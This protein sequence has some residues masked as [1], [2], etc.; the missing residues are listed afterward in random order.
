MQVYNLYPISTQHTL[1]PC[2]G[3][4]RPLLM[5]PILCRPEKNLTILARRSAS[6]LIAPCIDKIAAICACLVWVISWNKS[7]DKYL[8]IPMHET[9]SS[10][11]RSPLASNLRNLWV[12]TRTASSKPCKSSR[13]YPFLLDSGELEGTKTTSFGN[14]AK[15]TDLR[16][17]DMVCSTMDLGGIV[18][19]MKTWCGLVYF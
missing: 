6:P 16:T 7:S 10:S 8:S 2:F 3:N 18:P 9:S 14:D 11:G 1:Y 19:T 17:W 12:S 5:C 4:H 15:V 13:E